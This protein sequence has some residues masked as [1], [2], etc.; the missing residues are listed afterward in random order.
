MAKVIVQFN[1]DNDSFKENM[2]LETRLILEQAW[3]RLVAGDCE[4]HPSSLMD[5]NGNSVGSVSTEDE[6]EE[7]GVQ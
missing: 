6:E 4:F 7:E 5:S 1:T 3:E 2:N